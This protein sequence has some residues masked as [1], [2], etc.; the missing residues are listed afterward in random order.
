M[1][2]GETDSQVVQS[3]AGTEQQQSEKVVDFWSEENFVNDRKIDQWKLDVRK[4]FDQLDSDGS[5]ELDEVE[6]RTALKMMDIVLPIPVIT[7]VFE[8]IDLDKSDEISFDEF[9]KFLSDDSKPLEFQAEY[10]AEFSTDNIGLELV[11][12]EAHSGDESGD[13]HSAPSEKKNTRVFVANITDD[14]TRNYVLP[15]S[16]VISI[17]NTPVCGMSAKTIKELIHEKIKRSEKPC[18]ITFKKVSNAEKNKK[19]A[20]MGGL[21]MGDEDWLVLN[22]HIARRK[23]EH[24]VERLKRPKPLNVRTKHCPVGSPEENWWVWTHLTFEDETFS[25]L[26]NIIVTVITGLIFVSTLAYVLNTIPF[27]RQEPIFEQIEAFVSICFTVEYVA[28]IITSRNAWIFFVDGMSMV[29]FLAII[30]WWIQICFGSAGSGSILRVIRVIRLARVFRLLKTPFFVQFL[31]IFYITIMKSRSSGG[32]MLTILTLSVI[33]FASL[34][35]FA[36]KG[37]LDAITGENLRSDLAPSPFISIPASCWWCVVTMTTVGYGDMYPIETLGMVIATFTMLIGL[38]VIA[39]PVVIVGENF[40]T[41]YNEH[42][43][44]LETETRLKGLN[45]QKTYEQSVEHYLEEINQKINLASGIHWEYVPFFTAKDKREFVKENL[46]SRVK[47]QEIL[48]LG[49]NCAHF[50]P[51]S[52][53]G[54]KLFVL[55]QFFGKDLLGQKEDKFEKVKKRLAAKVQLF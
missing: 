39:L 20:Q 1:T 30:P 12:E 22:A 14:E 17:D 38:F 15:N 25:V 46:D 51:E 34:V 4:I 28:R 43:E 6:F 24:R 7:F 37:I 31:N 55:Y 18:Q 13:S 32:L 16:E 11:L 45:E 10:I 19:M 8:A 9:V 41:T 42:L 52:V 47:L 26:S 5:G 33:I 35:Y 3:F 27:F 50:F 21:K 53:Q 48:K 44:R 54:Y 36:E 49:P 23:L 29:D 2:A 40:T